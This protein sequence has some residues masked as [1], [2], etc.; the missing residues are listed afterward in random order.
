MEIKE[1]NSTLKIF[2]KESLKKLIKD[3][4]EK[5]NNSNKK[6]EKP[7]ISI[8]HVVNNLHIPTHS[9]TV[10]LPTPPTTYSNTNDVLMQMEKKLLSQIPQKPK[11]L[12]QEKTTTSTT[13]K[14]IISIVPKKTLN[15][16]KNTSKILKNLNEIKITK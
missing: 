14:K 1:K 4:K 9:S 11:N 16:E 7:I 13:I 3:S 8:S 10:H 12:K 6:E 15:E 2:N 5:I